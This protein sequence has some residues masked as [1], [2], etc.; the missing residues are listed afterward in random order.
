MFDLFGWKRNRELI[1]A[2][3]NLERAYN[4]LKEIKLN[5][6]EP[7]IQNLHGRLSKT[8]NL[9]VYN[10]KLINSAKVIFTAMR[11]DAER[12]N[13]T[14]SKVRAYRKKFFECEKDEQS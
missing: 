2:L 11:N 9:E 12:G 5:E 10:K 8:A 4:E 7:V 6:F 1:A 3:N 13:L 14:A